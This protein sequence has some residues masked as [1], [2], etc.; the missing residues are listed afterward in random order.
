MQ[1][2]CLFA[3]LGIVLPSIG[4]GQDVLRS[5]QY[6]DELP[7]G[8]L[9]R[10]GSVRFRQPMGCDAVAVSPDGKLLASSSVLGTVSAELVHPGWSASSTRSWVSGK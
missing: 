8:A 9:Q 1:K 5:D 4:A 7:L 2:A 3:L 6:G 10:F